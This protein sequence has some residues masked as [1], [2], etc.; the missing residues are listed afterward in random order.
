MFGQCKPR[1]EPERDRRGC[2][3][4]RGNSLRTAQ[5]DRPDERTMNRCAFDRLHLF[6]S[7]D[8]NLAWETSHGGIGAVWHEPVFASGQ[9][10][11]KRLKGRNDQNV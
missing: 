4:Y 10:P 7:R 3:D 8:S 1:T 5:Q 9:L 6:N 2:V 11:A